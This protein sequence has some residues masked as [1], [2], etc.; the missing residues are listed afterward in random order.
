MQVIRLVAAAARTMP[1]SRA[2]LSVGAVFR[3]ALLNRNSLRPPQLMSVVRPS[4]IGAEGME[5]GRRRLWGEK[6]TNWNPDDANPSGQLCQTGEGCERERVASR[7][8]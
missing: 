1:P 8:G 3:I 2:R 6:R 4:R 5:Q 7:S